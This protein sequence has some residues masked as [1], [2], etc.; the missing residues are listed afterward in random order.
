[1]N[2]PCTK[3]ISVLVRHSEWTQIEEAKAGRSTSAFI[4]EQLGLDPPQ[5][6]GRRWPADPAARSWRKQVP[7]Q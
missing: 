7:G 4:R 3:T 1:M 5:P 6:Q 2:S